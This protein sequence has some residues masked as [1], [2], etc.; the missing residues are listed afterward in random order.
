MAKAQVLK[1]GGAVSKAPM[2]TRLQRTV[3]GVQHTAPGTV[4][5]GIETGRWRLRLQWIEY[6]H[7]HDLIATA[8]PGQ[9]RAVIELQSRKVAE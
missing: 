6:V 8:Q 4:D 3:R 5:H 9:P 2:P 1:Q 7:Q